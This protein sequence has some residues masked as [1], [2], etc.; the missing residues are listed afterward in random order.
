MNNFWF[1]SDESLELVK[2]ASDKVT[3]MIASGKIAGMRDELNKI[4]Y[5]E[6]HG[7]VAIVNIAGSL[8]KG[9]AGWMQLFGVVGYD[10]LSKSVLEAAADPETKKL[11]FVFD[12][13]GGHV[14]GLAEFGRFLSQASKVKPSA[15]P[16][17]RPCR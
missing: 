12:S 15:P 11:L 13:G 9:D 1:G 17:G 14:A 8:V 7:D 2:E 10:N 3:A 16:C 5:W 6:R 4:S